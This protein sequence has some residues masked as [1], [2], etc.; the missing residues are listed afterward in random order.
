M[1]KIVFL[2]L[3]LSVVLLFVSCQGDTNAQPEET[4]GNEETVAETVTIAEVTSAEETIAETVTIAEATSDE[5][6]VAEI[7]TTEKTTETQTD[8]ET[9][10]YASE[11]ITDSVAA[12]V[13]KST[14]ELIAHSR[15]EFIKA[16]NDYDDV[17]QSLSNDITK[18]NILTY[19]IELS[20]CNIT[21][22]IYTEYEFNENRTQT[23]WDFDAY[24]NELESNCEIRYHIF[25]ISE[26][27][28]VSGATYGYQ[29][30]DKS[31][32]IYTKKINNGKTAYVSLIN[33]NMFMRMV[34]KNEC[35]NFDTI[36]NQ[37]LNY[38]LEIKNIAKYIDEPLPIEKPDS[39]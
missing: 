17:T 30:Y 9:T 5:E 39:N 37:L 34:V 20:G 4:T 33:D 21:T 18:Y 36:V 15:D 22:L 29:I 16:I 6:T 27:V 32:E 2:V 26:G 25:Y 31:N 14:A 24:W 7:V 11:I 28:D 3:L 10:E 12:D 35:N 23:D 1:K 19:P 38:A 8:D 13:D